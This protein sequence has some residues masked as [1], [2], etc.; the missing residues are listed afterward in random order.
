MWGGGANVN[1]A[2]TVTTFAAG[3][4]TTGHGVRIRGAFVT[5][6]DVQCSFFGGDGFNVIATAGS[7]GPVAGNA[8][9]FRLD[10][11]QSIYNR[12]NGY[13]FSGN[14]ANAGATY[15]CSAISNGGAGFLDYTFLG[16]AHRDAHVRD[17]GISDPT[18]SNGPTGS[19]LYASNLY[20][21]V[22]GRA[23]QASTE[24]PG[25]VTNGTEAWR[26]YYQGYSG[27]PWSTGL[28]W[29]CGAPYASNPGNANCSNL[30]FDNC[31]AESGQ[32]PCQVYAPGKL[33]G[34]LL[35]EAGMDKDANAPWLQ[36]GNGAFTAA[37][38][39]A[40]VY[41]SNRVA[42]LGANRGSPEP[43]TWIGYADGTY[44]WSLRSELVTGMAFSVE[45]RNVW[46]VDPDSGSFPSSMR[47]RTPV[48]SDVSGD[49]TL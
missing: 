24:V 45:S 49:Q 25:S 29:V 43:T 40:N 31:Y 12:G 23:A 26:R 27:R 47:L 39:K 38:F 10:N 22:A 48:I 30:V 9:N 34:G 28:E 7:T 21:V 15:I 32:S 44:F 16:N 41:G 42:S 17:C 14:D 8:N 1:S 2:G 19:A 11:C 36:A 6:V 18:G 4:S 33:M 35:F 37:C 3:D 20:Y 13:T 46:T 5:V